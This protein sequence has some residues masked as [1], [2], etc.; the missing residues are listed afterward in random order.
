MMLA[1]HGRDSDIDA[2]LFTLAEK[3]G[4]TVREVEEGMDHMEYVQWQ[5]FYIAKAAI[6]S[7][8]GG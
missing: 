6:G 3:L 4:K 1:L 7:V 8:R 2:F 5:A